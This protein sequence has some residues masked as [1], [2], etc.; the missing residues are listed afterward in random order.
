MINKNLFVGPLGKLQNIG[1]SKAFT[2]PNTI[3]VSPDYSFETTFQ[4]AEGLISHSLNGELWAFNRNSK[5]GFLALKWNNET[6]QLEAAA[7]EAL[8]S[9]TVLAR[10]IDWIITDKTIIA[11]GN[12]E[13]YIFTAPL[14]A[15][16]IPKTFLYSYIRSNVANYDIFTKDAWGKSSTNGNSDGKGYFS[17]NSHLLYAPNSHSMD[18]CYSLLPP[19]GDWQIIENFLVRRPHNPLNNSYN[20]QLNLRPLIPLEVYDGDSHYGTG[21]NLNHI[22]VQIILHNGQLWARGANLIGRVFILPAMIDENGEILEYYL[23][24]NNTYAYR[25]RDYASVNDDWYK[26]KLFSLGGQSLYG[27]LSDEQSLLS[28]ASCIA[29]KNTKIF[30]LDKRI[31]IDISENNGKLFID[32]ANSRALRL[33]DSGAIFF[34]SDIENGVAFDCKTLPQWIAPSED[35]SVVSDNFIASPYDNHLIF[36]ELNREF[37]RTLMNS[38]YIPMSYGF[39]PYTVALNMT[40]KAKYAKL[41]SVNV[42][43]QQQQV[44]PIPW[45]DVFRQPVSLRVINSGV[46]NEGNLSL[47]DSN[48]PLFEGGSGNDVKNVYGKVCTS[49]TYT[50]ETIFGLDVEE[51]ET[52]DIVVNPDD[53]TTVY[54]SLSARLSV[55]KTYYSISIENGSSSSYPVSISV[56]NPKIEHFTHTMDLA[57]DLTTWKIPCLINDCAVTYLE[58]IG[59]IGIDNSRLMANVS[60][61]QYNRYKRRR[62]PSIV[63]STSQTILLRNLPQSD[64][65]WEANRYHFNVYTNTGVPNLI[66]VKQEGCKARF[67]YYLN[68][69]EENISIQ[70]FRV[71]NFHNSQDTEYNGEFFENSRHLLYLSTDSK[72][73]YFLLEFAHNSDPYINI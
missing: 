26:T 58:S 70:D 43:S 55:Q 38:R 4:Y 65:G 68:L 30:S 42:I 34:D 53:S 29:A 15:S 47:V 49:I 32:I 12:Q 56:K 69:P 48:Y 14:Y 10:G 66:Y 28:A 13:P 72:F 37:H 54:S 19:V 27:F 9:Q 57:Y 7:T 20:Y 59:N 62:M 8:K 40:E 63:S 45:E 35:I 5:I 6:S 36:S 3:A 52:Y 11:S 73:F 23:Y 39:S 51:S 24:I 1:G 21:Y 60:R 67:Y 50:G 25:S 41:F 22:G 18:Q 46:I 17:K 64:W 44:Q 31:W 61:T 71:L 2:T 16:N 33:H